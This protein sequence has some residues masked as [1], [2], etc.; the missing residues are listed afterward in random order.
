MACQ[1]D[2]SLESK[3]GDMTIQTNFILKKAN[4][5]GVHFV[6]QVRDQADFNVI[7]YRNFYNGG[8]V[9]IGD[10]NNDGLADIY[11]TANLGSNKLYLNKGDFTFEDITESS[12]TSGA[13]AW[14]TGVTMADVNA[15]GLLDIY[16]S[17]S[18]DVKGDNKLNELFINT[19]NLTFT[20]Q[21]K[22]F[23]LD[24]NGY[25]TQA[26]FFDYDADG[27]LD[28]YLLNNSF[29]DPAKIELYKSM[30][31]TPDK[32]S[33][34]K[35]YRNDN[36]K[37]VDVTSEAGIYS[38]AIG[39][40]LGSSIGDINQ[41]YL[42]DIYVSNDFWERDYLYINNGDGTFNDELPER[43]N[44]SSISSMGGDIADI[45]NDGFP[46]IISTDM[47]PADNYRIKAA[48]SGNRHAEQ[49]RCN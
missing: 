11:F 22:A 28:C 19:G 4:D 16:V 46:E 42:P 39:F 12:G 49:Y 3:H 41:D 24:N 26:S 2:Q 23:G 43:I 14:S 6:N 25:S 30:R 36:G 38:S 32:L 37:F 48:I 20:E 29:K 5:T 9:A 17:N 13:Q 31:D 21:A 35:L 10:I 1:S 47:L 27:D 18:G 15:D 45:N 7:S 33:G 44:Y 40:G 34:D 8:G